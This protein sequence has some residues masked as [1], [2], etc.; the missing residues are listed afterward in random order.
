MLVGQALAGDLRECQFEA[1]VIVHVIPVVV[2]EGL[3]IEVSKQ[4]EGLDTN[5]G[6]VQAAFQERPEFFQTY[7]IA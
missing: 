3:L 7:W 5:V 6:A 4:V 1:F 2:A